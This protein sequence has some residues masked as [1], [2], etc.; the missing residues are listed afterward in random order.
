MPIFSF[1]GY[2]LTELFRKLTIDDRFINKRLR[3]FI[4]QTMYLK[5]VEKKLLGRH[6][7]GISLKQICKIAV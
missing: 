5:R 7:K 4:Y 6:S 1:I 2:T 3:L